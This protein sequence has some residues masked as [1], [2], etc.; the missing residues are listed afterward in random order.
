M[1]PSFK[2]TARHTA[3]ASS[4]PARDFYHGVVEVDK[5]A[6]AHLLRQTDDG[7]P[8]GGQAVGVVLAVERGLILAYLALQDDLAVPGFAGGVAAREVQHAICVLVPAEPVLYVLDLARRIHA[9]A[10]AAG[11]E[12]AQLLRALLAGHP[13]QAAD[14]AVLGDLDVARAHTCAERVFP[15]P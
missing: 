3:R 1:R 15:A 11:Y 9:L 7:Q 6:V 8:V 2:Y 5:D 4:C 10:E 14:L 12:A 13:R